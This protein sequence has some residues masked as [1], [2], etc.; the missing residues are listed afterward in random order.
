MLEKEIEKKVSDYAVSK[1][2]LSYKF[3]SPNRRSVPDRIFIS[4]T[5]YMWFCEFKRE[6][7]VPTPAQEREI[8]KLRNQ[9]CPVCVVDN[10][11]SG[12]EMVTDAMCF[13]LNHRLQFTEC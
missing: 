3:T 12:M 1:G 4:P 2:C 10:V 8:S 6:G 5:G 7:K 11:D 13:P 9:G